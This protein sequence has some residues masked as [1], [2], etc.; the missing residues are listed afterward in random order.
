MTSHQIALLI[1]ITTS[2]LSIVFASWNFWRIKYAYRAR[3][4]R[5][6]ERML[7]SRGETLVDL[8]DVPFC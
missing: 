7:Q 3:G 4:R 5:A 8:R 1:A 2:L 6:V